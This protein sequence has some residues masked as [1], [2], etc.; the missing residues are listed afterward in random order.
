MIPVYLASYGQPNVVGG[1]DA[2]SILGRLSQISQKFGTKMR[3]EQDKA[4]LEIPE[5]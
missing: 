4:F 3:I 1:A 5:D 2:D